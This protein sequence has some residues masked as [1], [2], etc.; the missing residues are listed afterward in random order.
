MNY[1]NESDISVSCNPGCWLAE[2]VFQLIPPYSNSSG[3]LLV[4][5]HICQSWSILCLKHACLNMNAF[6]SNTATPVG[7]DKWPCV[8][9]SSVQ[10]EWDTRLSAS[11]L[12][13]SALVSISTIPA[14][15]AG[16]HFTHVFFKT[17][18][19]LLIS[20][21]D[22]RLYSSTLC[23]DQCRMCVDQCC[24]SAFSRVC[25]VTRLVSSVRSFVRAGWPSITSASWRAERRST[26]LCWPPRACPGSK[27][28]R[29]ATLG[30]YH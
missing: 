27:T 17:H 1:S 10:R 20:P 7:G 26:G 29:W 9:K 5:L 21:I 3:S 16:F 18:L 23:I 22:H 4:S 30:R 15:C 28:T 2:T 8:F 25:D 11:V 24:V 19:T 6:C 14:A 13:Y 12:S